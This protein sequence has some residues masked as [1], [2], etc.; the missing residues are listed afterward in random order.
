[1]FELSISSDCEWY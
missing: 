1:M